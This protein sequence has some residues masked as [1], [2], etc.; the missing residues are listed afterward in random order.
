[1][2]GRKSGFTLVELLIVVAILALVSGAAIALYNGV[3]TDSAENVSISTQQELMNT[4]GSYMAAHNNK[5][6]DGYD[7][8]LRDIAAR[9]YT[10]TYTAIGTTLE[11][12]DDPKDAIYAGYDASPVDNV[13]D[14][15]AGSKGVDTA[16]YLGH[17]RS[18]TVGK[19][20]DSDIATLKDLGITYVYDIL[21]TADFFHGNVSYVK[22]TLKA[23]DPVCMIDPR[24]AR[25]G[26][27]VYK[28]FGVDLSDTATY[29]R[30]AADVNTGDYSVVKND[31]DDAGRAA[32][33]K[34]QRFFVFGLGPNMTMLGDR[35]G[36]LQ[37]ASTCA[38]VKDGY[39]NRY[40][41][42]V[43]M[44]GG[45]NDMNP[46]VAGVLD[47]KGKT[48]RGAKSWATRTE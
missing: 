22:R 39:Y 33:L 34:K 5:L 1:M 24:T 28:D 35:K 29:T 47:A 40:F 19:L 17:F 4:L 23:G 48:V 32:A 41:L 38:I 11:V 31:L 8:L 27:S 18:L 44:P 30:A 6:S 37:E 2:S 7:S 16:A 10:G 3:F 42:V 15:N 46:A 13:A 25:N 36:G 9:P 26:I 12:A 45:P 14:T 20:T 43:K 21:T